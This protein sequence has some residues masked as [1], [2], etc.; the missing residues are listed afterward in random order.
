MIRT[1]VQMVRVVGLIDGPGF[2]VWGGAGFCIRIFWI[3][4]IA[5][6]LDRSV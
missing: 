2:S 3:T 5:K 4:F 1:V 6:L